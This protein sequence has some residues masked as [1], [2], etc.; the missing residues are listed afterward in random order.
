MRSFVALWR[1]V[2]VGGRT[3]EMS[4]LRALAEREGLAQVRTLLRTGNLAF[5]SGE[6]S[7][8]ELE[9][10]LEAASR[11]Q[12]GLESD[13][14]VR[15]GGEL[16]RLREANPFPEFAR[17]DPSHLLVVFLKTAPAASAPA[18]AKSLP[19]PEELRVVGAQA[20][21][22]YPS[23]IG[24]SRLTLSRIE[25]GL[26]TRGTARNWNTVRRLEA[27]VAA[28]DGTGIERPKEGG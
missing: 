26:G 10:R 5:V 7:P 14:I 25:S 27:L 1:A 20:Y 2:N 16:A 28:S 22:R 11:E 15:T 4:A 21:V 23:G 18:F 12:L 9:R 17:R 8:R 13:V 6:S 24:R 3:L 19:G